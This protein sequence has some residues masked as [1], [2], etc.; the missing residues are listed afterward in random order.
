M[1]GMFLNNANCGRWSEIPTVRFPDLILCCDEF[2]KILSIKVS[3]WWDIRVGTEIVGNTEYE[4]IVSRKL[5]T[6]WLF[7]LSS[8]LIF[9]SQKYN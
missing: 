5:I 8:R 2:V 6:S 4:L 9:V 3:D 1:Q 7:I